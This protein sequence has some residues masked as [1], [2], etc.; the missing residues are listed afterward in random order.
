MTWRS[1]VKS[2][3]QELTNESLPRKKYIIRFRSAK[4]YE[5]C[6]KQ[7]KKSI[8]SPF[9]H[10]SITL[11]PAIRAFA[12]SLRTTAELLSS[13]CIESIEFDTKI[14]LAIGRGS[15]L[16]SPTLI[17]TN[18]NRPIP[19]GI[20]HIKAP[21]LWKHTSGAGI[22][23]GVIDTGVDVQHAD[24]SRC[25][26][27]GVNLIRQGTLPIDDNGH[28]TH[29]TGTIAASNREGMLGIAPKAIIHPVKAFD[30]QGSAYISDIIMGIEWCIRQ[31]VDIINMSF[32]MKQRNQALCDAVQYA[33]KSG[34]IVVASSGN[35][36]KAKGIDYPARFS[37]TI[38]VGASDRR[39][40]IASF[41]NR[42]QNLDLYAPGDRIIST[43]PGGKYAQLNGTSMATSHVTG[44]I[45]LLLSK[46]PE[47]KP[48]IIKTILKKSSRKVIRKSAKIKRKE[49]VGL[50]DAP[51]ALRT[52]LL[53]PRTLRRS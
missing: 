20:R 37:Q 46:H 29:I 36:G 50:L 51:D 16:A 30:H 40:K 6:S 27:N 25:L 14:Q 44:V 41:S 10:Q 13:P 19:W 34:I 21:Q 49:W 26:G 47:L 31:R 11:I 33:Q 28:G 17:K 43:W 23:I 32:G 4:D 45:A 35:D 42:G 2:L 1:F 38:A 48:L 24:L 52:V 8:H 5:D 15:P 18:L 9:L 7:L 39:N 3:Q 12:C 22:H 53:K